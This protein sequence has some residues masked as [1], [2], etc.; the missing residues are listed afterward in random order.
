MAPRAPPNPLWGVGVERGAGG[1]HPQPVTPLSR[2]VC[3]L[4]PGNGWG[5]IWGLLGRFGVGGGCREQGGDPGA[6]RAKMGVVG[7]SCPPPALGTALV[8]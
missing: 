3:V 4:C 7:S 8:V 6:N 5:A 2:H 1:A